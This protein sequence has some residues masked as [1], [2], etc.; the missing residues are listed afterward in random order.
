VSP[1]S[2]G[3]KLE[4]GHYPPPPAT[5]GVKSGVTFGGLFP[6]IIHTIR[7]L[8]KPAGRAASCEQPFSDTDTPCKPCMTE[9]SRDYSDVSTSEN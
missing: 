6:K 5:P 4:H 7:R 9:R 8:V 1:E 3:V 2:R